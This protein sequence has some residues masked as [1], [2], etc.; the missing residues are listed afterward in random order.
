M[1][2]VRKA[3]ISDLNTIVSLAK[4]LWPEQTTKDLNDELSALLDKS[5][6]CIMIAFKEK[7]PIGFAQCQLRYNYVEG[8]HSSPVGYLEGIYIKPSERNNG[9]ARQ[10]LSECES[11][12][13]Q[14]GCTEF[15]SDCES[16]NKSVMS[17]TLRKKRTIRFIFIR[18]TTDMIE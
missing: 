8:T 5:D 3:N 4:A 11:W 7:A 6:A 10:L 18:T 14:K 2:S 17:S 15:A 13:K 1:K 16:Q 9:Y 12:A